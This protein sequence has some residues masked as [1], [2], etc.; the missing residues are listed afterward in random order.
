MPILDNFLECIRLRK[1]VTMVG[2][3]TLSGY[4]LAEDA[5]AAYVSDAERDSGKRDLLTVE[6]R[7][8]PT[9]LIG[10]LYTAGELD[11]FVS[12]LTQNLELHSHEKPMYI[13]SKM[14]M[15]RLVFRGV[16]GTDQFDLSVNRAQAD[17]EL[18][19]IWE[20]RGTDAEQIRKLEDK[21]ESGYDLEVVVV[22]FPDENFAGFDYSVCDGRLEIQLKMLKEC[23]DAQFNS[24]AS[25]TGA[26]S[27]DQAIYSGVCDR[28]G[29]VA[30]SPHTFYS[31]SVHLADSLR[32]LK[33]IPEF[34]G[35]KVLPEI[36]GAADRMAKIEEEQ[37]RHMPRVYGFREASSRVRVNDENALVSRDLSE[38]LKGL[39]RELIP[40]LK[41]LGRQR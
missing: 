39:T 12:T 25:E 22:P 18:Q 20:A 35:S 13:G 10:G 4:E 31:G 2:E 15:G 5:R 33:S 41:A 3:A 16:G 1:D 23:Q 32:S 29:V 6:Y 40:Q 17:R 38:A 21:H 11:G 37:S 30:F 34:E 27:T 7:V 26:L 19:K 14:R 28:V 36:M 8:A 24:I 9:S